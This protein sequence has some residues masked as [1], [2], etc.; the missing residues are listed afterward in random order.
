LIDGTSV[1]SAQYGDPRPD[2]AAA[3]PDYQNANSGFHFALDTTTL[4]NGKHSLTVKET[5]NNGGTLLLSTQTVNVSNLAVKGYMESPTN[6]STVQGVTNVSGWFLDANGVS[7]IEVLVDGNSVGQAQYG[8]ARP[9]VAKAFPE[10]QNANSGYQFALDTKSLTNGQHSLTIRETANNG[11]TN[12]LASQTVNVQ[13][14]SG[15]KGYIESPTNGSTVQGVTN[16]SGWFLDA[17]GVSKIEVLVD[18]NSVGQAQYGSARPDVAKAFPEYQ[19]ANSGF[20]Y[21]LD[22]KSLTNGQHTLT[23]K[24]TGNGGVVNVLTSEKINVQNSPVRGNIETPWNGST[25][26]GS[27]NVSG[28]LLDISG[29][30]KIEVLVD[31]NSI[32]QAQYGSARPDVA[33]AYPEYQN[34]FSGY[35]YTVDTK[36]LTNGLHTLTVKETGNNGGTNIV[37]NLSVNIQNPPPNGTIDEPV[38]GSSIKGIINVDGW[39]LDE[40]GISKIEIIVDGNS[41]G[42]AQYGNSR[43]DVAKAFPEYQ[44]ANSGYQYSLNTKTLTN[45]QHQLTVKETGNNGGTTLLASQSINVQNPPAKGSIDTPAYLS[46]IKGTATVQGWFLDGSDI[47]KIEVL[48]DGNILG[49]AQYGSARPDVAAAFPE[50]QNGNSGYQ[51]SFDTQQVPDG[52]HVITVRETGTNG[53]ITKISS[54]VL[55][56]NGDPYT[57]IDLRKPANITAADLVNFFNRYYPN[58]PLINDVQ[59]FMNAQATYGVNAQYLAAHAVWETGWG[60]SNIYIYKHNLF[61]YGA[62]DLD[63]FN[64]AYYFPTDA[65]S[66]NWEG[67]IV[68]KNYLDPTGKYY[69]GSTLKGMNVRYAT[70]QNWSNGIAGLMEEIKPFNYASDYAY[71]CQ[72]SILPTSTTVPTTYGSSIPVG[73][74][75]P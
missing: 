38:N 55:V 69:N 22:T 7:K 45:G 31:G 50:Y 6:G 61:G 21:S 13:N 23:I 44:N 43:P 35:Q 1:G 19:N 48:I 36:N 24:E 26:K 59:Y 8:S 52:Q 29:V 4:T 68:R 46:T 62:Y 49:Q 10:Y 18:G 5:G 34:G 66:I 41:V 47:A 42:Q 71:Y 51:F 3:M 12:V 72:V 54:T 14:N 58:S 60:K 33:K 2:V 25:V 63:P 75:T 65:D 67:Y 15:A 37:G 39:F 74:P 53:T 11:T 64:S 73:L 16:V 9:D 28:W 27:I 17:N 56:S 40:S 57:L 30:S 20:Q 70:D 32:G